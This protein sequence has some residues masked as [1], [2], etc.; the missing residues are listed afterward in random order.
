MMLMALE[1]IATPTKGITIKENGL[2]TYLPAAANKNFPMV[3]IIKGNLSKGLNL[4]WEGMSQIPEFMKDNLKMANFKEKVL[5]L[6]WIIV[7]TLVTGKM[8]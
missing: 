3:L 7:D 6:T 1:L 4:E 2:Q 5:S 8:A